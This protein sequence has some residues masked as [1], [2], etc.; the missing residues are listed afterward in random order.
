M[1]ELITVEVHL[2]LLL[3]FF[4]VMLVS[5][6]AMFRW[7]RQAERERDELIDSALREAQRKGVPGDH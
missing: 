4:C 1:I 2:W 3:T 6:M 5:W 7:M